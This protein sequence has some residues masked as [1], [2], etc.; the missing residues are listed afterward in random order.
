MSLARIPQLRLRLFCFPLAFLEYRATVTLCLFFVTSWDNSLVLSSSFLAARAARVRIFFDFSDSG[1]ER[2]LRPS[3]HS[4]HENSPPSCFT[5]HGSF[6]ALLGSFIA[7]SLLFCG[8]YSSHST[9]VFLSLVVPRVPFP[10]IAQPQFL[11][12]CAFLRCARGRRY[13][14]APNS[15]NHRYMCTPSTSCSQMFSKHLLCLL[16][17]FW[18]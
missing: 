5:F 7:P 17:A 2:R 12:L 1:T 8:V 9:C 18:K 6:I 14:Y 4:L 11:F 13:V 15:L 16:S 10:Q 3:A